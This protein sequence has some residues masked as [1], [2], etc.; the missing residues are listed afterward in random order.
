M[1]TRIIVVAAPFLEREARMRQRAELR[2][3]EALVAQTSVEGFDEGV[4]RR[5]ARRDVV[6]CHMATLRPCEDSVAGELRAVVADDPV[7]LAAHRD[8]PI[9]FARHPNAR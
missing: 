3:V 4:L 1:R 6:P 8:H 9:E 5:L 2:L 7:G